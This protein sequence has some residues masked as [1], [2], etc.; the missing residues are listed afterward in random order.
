[1][2]ENAGSANWVEDA[3]RPRALSARLQAGVRSA[4][5]RVAVISFFSRPSASQRAPFKMV[6][7][8]PSELRDKRKTELLKVLEEHKTEL[9]QV[10]E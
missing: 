7:T 10:R 8:K 6:K 9:S 5:L 1:M 3:R 2:R 4:R